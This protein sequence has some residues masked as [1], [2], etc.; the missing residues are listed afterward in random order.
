VLLVLAQHLLVRFHWADALHIGS[1]TMGTFGVYLFFVH[2]CL[3]LMYSM[4]RSHLNGSALVEN[5]YIR[6][7]FRIYPLSIIAVLAAVALRLDSMAN[8][9]PGLSHVASIPTGRIL[10]NLLLIQNLIKPGSIINVLWSLPY[11]VQMYVFL[12]FLFLWIR[13]KQNALRMLRAL[14]VIAVIVAILYQQIAGTFPWDRIG[15]VLFVPCFLPGVIAFVLPHIPKFKSIFW[16]PFL[17]ILVGV[18]MLAPFNRT[19]WA[20]CL[21][22]GVAIPASGN[23]DHLV[24]LDESLDRYVLLW[25]LSLASILYLAGGGRLQFVPGWNQVPDAG[26]IADCDP[27]CP[28]SRGRKAHDRGWDPGGGLVDA[29]RADR[30]Q[31]SV[32][33][34]AE[35]AREKLAIA[36]A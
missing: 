31:S 26:G 34:E 5:F 16:L 2:T 20:L 28:I 36:E 30:A 13:G 4:E 25:D 19:G 15:L 10:S 11:E 8:G 22:L 21:I 9:I 17:L 6:R 29:G 32:D 14:W 33:R 24:A 12:P 1:P 27:D 35:K 7:I 3:V 18:Y 23:T